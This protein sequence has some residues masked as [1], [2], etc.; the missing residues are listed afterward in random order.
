M[1]D[2]EHSEELV[3]GLF[4]RGELGFAESRDK[5]I[6]LK[7][8]RM[9]PTF[10]NGRRIMSFSPNQAMPL[11]KQR[12]IAQLTVEGYAHGVD[13]SKNGFDHLI[14]LPQAVNPIVGAIALL[15]GK[16][17]LYLRTLEG[18]KGYGKHQPIEGFFEEG[19]RVL[20]IDNVVSDAKTKDEVTAPIQSAGLVIP[21]F[22]VLLDREEGGEAAI[23]DGGR[24]LTSVVGMGAATQILV[25]AGR[26]SAEQAAWSFDYIERYQVPV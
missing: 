17:L 22:V 23:K 2:F 19:D 24:D 1:A 3:V 25:D 12:R 13:Q 14:N 7:S 8:G 11:A 26:I 6:K 10:F 18:E 21:E 4:D 15:S 16:S 5:F 9:S 20:G